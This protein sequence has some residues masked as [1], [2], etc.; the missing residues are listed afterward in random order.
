VLGGG[1][2][3]EVRTEAEFDEAL[4]HAWEDRKN[5]SLIHVHL[6]VTDASPALLRLAERLGQRVSG[7][8]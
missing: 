5:V 3:Y 1:C 6:S 4:R 7:T 2:G 8:G